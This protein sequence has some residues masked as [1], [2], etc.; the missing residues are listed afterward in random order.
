MQRGERRAIGQGAVVGGSRRFSALYYILIEVGHDR[1]VS[2][3]RLIARASPPDVHFE[4]K[5]LK[6]IGSRYNIV[7]CIRKSIVLEN[8]CRRTPPVR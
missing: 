8:C 4:G 5:T 6:Y 1:L 2:N 7:F 3:A